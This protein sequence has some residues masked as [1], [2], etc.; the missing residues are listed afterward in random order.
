MTRGLAVVCATV[1]VLTAVSGCSVQQPSYNP[2]LGGFPMPNSYLG[3][4]V[5]GKINL[6]PATFI[7]EKNESESLGKRNLGS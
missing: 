6:N 3:Q 5:A 4:S 2:V 1:V 7:F